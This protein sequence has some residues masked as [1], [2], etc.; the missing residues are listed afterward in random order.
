ML[1]RKVTC[2]GHEVGWAPPKHYVA[3]ARRCVQLS[4]LTD[5]AW[6]LWPEQEVPEDSRVIVFVGNATVTF[7][8]IR[9]ASYLRTSDENDS[10]TV[11]RD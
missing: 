7:G 3:A 1:G 2:G 10:L 5:S 9:L 8:T 4:D 6:T 11:P